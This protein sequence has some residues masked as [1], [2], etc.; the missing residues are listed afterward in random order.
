MFNELELNKIYKNAGLQKI[1]K[2]LKIQTYESIFM[3]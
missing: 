1:T 3:D 2:K